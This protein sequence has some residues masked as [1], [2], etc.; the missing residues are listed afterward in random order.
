MSLVENHL[1]DLLRNRL[2]AIAEMEVDVERVQEG[3]EAIAHL[4][5]SPGKPWAKAD[6]QFVVPDDG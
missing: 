6:N 3:L 1:D 4:D 2:P 5:P